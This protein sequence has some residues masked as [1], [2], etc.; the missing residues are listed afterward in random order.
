MQEEKNPWTIIDSILV[1][2]NP[3]LAVKHHNVINPK[4]GK[5]IYG[6][7]EFKNI[8]LG[9]VPIDNEGNTWLV[10]QYRLA[11][12]NYSW[13]IPQGGCPLQ[14]EPLVEAKR[15]LLEE[16]GLIANHWQQLITTHLSNSVTNEKN[17]IF[18]AKDLSE[19]ASQPEDT[20]Q[21][22][23]KKLPLTQAFDMIANCEIT[24]A[25]SIIGLQKVQLLQLQGKL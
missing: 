5:G 14:K 20:E 10:G 4:G 18:L 6:I 12:N 24:D 21:L 16:T 15:E 25:V 9:I 8:A 13:E 7:V 11:T 23:V 22:Q 3:W 17:I 2:D 1:Y 19:Q